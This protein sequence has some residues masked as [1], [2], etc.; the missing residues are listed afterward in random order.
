MYFTH[1]KNISEGATDPHRFFYC[2][3]VKCDVDPFLQ[4]SKRNYTLTQPKN[5]SRTTLTI[6]IDNPH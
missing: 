5:L 4:Q 2:A 1:I 6:E 3:L